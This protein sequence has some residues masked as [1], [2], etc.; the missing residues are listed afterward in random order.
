VRELRDYRERVRARLAEQIETR[1][2][3]LTDGAASTHEQYRK[4]VGEI[5]GLKIA[6]LVMDEACRQMLEHDEDDP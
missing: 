5:T 3:S 2:V 1:T 4:L 6:L